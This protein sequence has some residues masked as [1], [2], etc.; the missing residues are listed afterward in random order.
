MNLTNPDAAA[1]P[2]TAKRKAEGLHQ[3]C[4]SKEVPLSRVWVLPGP[5]ASSVRREEC[6]GGA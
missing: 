5:L 1:A 4:G 2:R 3:V 6:A